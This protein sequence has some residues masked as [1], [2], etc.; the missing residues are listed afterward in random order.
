[1]KDIGLELN[2]HKYPYILGMSEVHDVINV[3]IFIFILH[4]TDQYSQE[5]IKLSLNPIHRCYYE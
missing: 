5:M 3:K 1:M 2:T 4:K